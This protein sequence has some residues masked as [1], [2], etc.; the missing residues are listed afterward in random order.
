M[1]SGGQHNLSRRRFLAL[2][3]ASTAAITLAAHGWPVTSSA[4]EHLTFSDVRL[5]WQG[6]PWSALSVIWTTPHGRSSPALTLSDSNNAL[7]HF[8]GVRRP[9]LDLAGRSTYE[10]GLRFLSAATVYG[11]ELWD[12]EKRYQPSLYRFTTGGYPAQ[13][14]PAISARMLA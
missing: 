9:D 14:V 6:R 10:V 1:S 8:E 12:T 7:R 4:E 13:G 11:F 5:Y 2:T 3:G